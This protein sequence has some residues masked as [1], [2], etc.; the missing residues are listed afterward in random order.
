MADDRARWRRLFD[1]V[2]SIGEYPGEPET[3]RSGRRV[4]LIGF[5]IAT[6]F[7]L[8]QVVQDLAAGYTVVGAM[9]LASAVLT[10]PFLWR[11][12]PGRT[13]SRRSSTRCSR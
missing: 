1:P 8:V 13:G 11:S 5:V 3:R 12:V 4:F 2:L 7:A 9:N 10:L 6:M